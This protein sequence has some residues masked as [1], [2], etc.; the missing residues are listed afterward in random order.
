VSAFEKYQTTFLLRGLKLILFLYIIDFMNGVRVLFIVRV[1][2][3]R[4]VVV[5]F[6]R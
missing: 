2:V 1:M 4:Y 3:N 5:I 6:V